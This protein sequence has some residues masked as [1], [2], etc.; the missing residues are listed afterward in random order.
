ME[1]EKIV[2]KMLFII[3][4]TFVFNISEVY[5]AP[6]KSASICIDGYSYYIQT[7]NPNQ[8]FEF[9]NLVGKTKSELGMNSN[10]NNDY[11]GRIIGKNGDSYVDLNYQINTNYFEAPKPGYQDLRPL[12]NR[13]YT[14]TTT[15]QFPNGTD[16]D[17]NQ[18]TTTT[19]SHMLK[20]C[21]SNYGFSLN[22][23]TS[24]KFLNNIIDGSKLKK[25]E[26]YIKTYGSC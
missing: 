10:G 19:E 22:F 18:I 3:L 24:D 8:T 7:A 2:K 21:G 5:A 26:D 12:N 4:L 17:G 13:C 1:L 25:K 9:A 15:N 14:Y 6:S 11:G 16:A 23:K 20:Q